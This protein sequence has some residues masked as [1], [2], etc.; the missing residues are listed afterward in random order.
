V[1]LAALAAMLVWLGLNQGG[2][3]IMGL[4]MHP[5]FTITAAFALIPLLPLLAGARGNG[6]SVALSLV[7]AIGL[8]VTAGLRPAFSSS[9]PER[10]NL[11]YIEREGKAWWL[12]GTTAHLPDS[13]RAAADF[14][15]MPRRVVEMGYVAAAGPAR[16][17][18]PGASVSRDGDTVT[19]DLKTQGDGVTLMV[20]AEAKLRSAQ[21]GGVT[22]PAFGRRISLVCG[23]PDCAATRM[24]LNLASSKPVSLELLSYRAGLPPDGAKLLKARPPEA[25]PSQGGDRTVLAAKIAIPAR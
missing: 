25:V 23:T 13:L 4:Q 9:A 5:L 22:V 8:A 15:A 10:L 2:E 19:L 18:P 1:F 6:V 24:I 14:S 12:A 21:I 20:P 17:A 3:V 16:Y 7:L 11:R